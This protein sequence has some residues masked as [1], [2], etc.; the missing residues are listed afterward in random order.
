MLCL[1]PS[2]CMR[3]LFRAAVDTAPRFARKICAHSMVYAVSGSVTVHASLALRGVKYPSPLLC[4]TIYAVTGWYMPSPSPSLCT[5]LLLR[6]FGHLIVS[7]VYHYTL[8]AVHTSLLHRTKVDTVLPSAMAVVLC[9]AQRHVLSLRGMFCLS[10]PRSARMRDEIAVVRTVVNLSIEG[11]G[12][13]C[14]EGLR[15]GGRGCALCV[16]GRAASVLV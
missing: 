2:R 8:H 3:L 1:A 6:R 9:S 5:C 13:V 4:V 7:S 11:G 12:G 16:G 14:G 15:E 10:E